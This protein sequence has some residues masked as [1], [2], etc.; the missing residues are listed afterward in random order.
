MPVSINF[1]KERRRSLTKTQKQDQMILRSTLIGFGGVLVVFM[2]VVGFQ[3]FLTYRFTQLKNRH[4]Q[5]NQTILSQDSTERSYLIL[6]NKVKVIAQLLKARTGKQQ[7]IEYFTNLFGPEVIIRELTYIERDN[8]LSFGLEA[9]N[10]F[11]LENLL[12]L[13]T[14]DDVSSRFASLSTSELTRT[15][16]GSY[17]LLVT[18]SLEPPA[19]PRP[20]AGGATGAG[21]TS[22]VGN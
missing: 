6:T 1:V 13:L 9:N 17:N 19:T 15:S 12:E 8:I 7:A 3:F 20:A 11:V 4:D 14:S 18:V 22:E 5:L 21:D 10:I 16:L 2:I